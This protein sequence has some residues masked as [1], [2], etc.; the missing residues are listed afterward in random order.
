MPRLGKLAKCHHARG[1]QIQVSIFKREKIEFLDLE[2]RVENGRLETNLYVK[3]S[4]LQLFLDYFSNHPQ[5]CKEG[6]IFGQALRI[7]ERC[8]KAEDLEKNLD[9][10]AEK[11]KERNYPETLIQEKF[12]K[13]RKIDRAD[14]LKSRKK[15][16]PDGKVRGIFTY[17]TTNPPLQK[18]IRL[19][20]KVLIKNE[21]A[22][23]I[24]N[25]IQ[26]GWKQSTNLQRITCGI[27]CGPK[28]HIQTTKGVLSVET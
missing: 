9:S 28:K 10:L 12:Q 17:N 22:K 21:K 1:D 13:A 15:K 2:V 5:H 14:I 20:K 7:I 25:R 18:W 3:P 11:L 16:K 27:M 24:G 6:I 23:A 8:S 4:N 26:I 19:S